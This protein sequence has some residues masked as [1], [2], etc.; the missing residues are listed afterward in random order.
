MSLILRRD[1]CNAYSFTFFYR[2]SLIQIELYTKLFRVQVMNKI[3]LLLFILL[4]NPAFAGD[5]WEVNSTSVGPDGSAQPF[6]QKTCFPTGGAD[7]SKML[8][9]LG[10]CT[11]DQKNG[12]ASAM[13]F[14]MTCKIPG[15]PADLASMK[16]TGE[17]KLMG[18]NFA[19]R[20]TISLGG[21]Q[22]LSGGDFKM[23]GDLEARKV[24]SCT[25]R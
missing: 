3:S 20:Y 21:D 22:K 9:G 17:A 2:I 12:D 10:S 4:A 11:M 5:L 24:G 6:T 1:F 25:E 18:N 15:M 13:T 16:V 7:P 8:E 23:N 14:A 19:M